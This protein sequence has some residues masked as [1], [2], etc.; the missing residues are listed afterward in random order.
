MVFHNEIKKFANNDTTF[1]EGMYRY[2]FNESERTPEHAE[3]LQ[4]RFFEEV[5]KRSGVQRSEMPEAWTAHPVVRWAGLAI[6]NAVVNSLLPETLNP[7]M[8]IFTDFKPV[9]AGDIVKVKIQPRAL[10]VVSLGNIRPT[11]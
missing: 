7:T 1:F 10:Y 3:K 6:V 9:G 5:E 8:G 11:C 4:A 2:H